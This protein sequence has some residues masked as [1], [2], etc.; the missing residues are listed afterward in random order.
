MLTFLNYSE[1]ADIII[2]AVNAS[3]DG[4]NA[5]LMQ[6]SRNLKWL[7]HIIRFKSNVWNPQKQVYDVEKRKC[8]SILLTLKKLQYWLYEMHF[9]LK[10]NANTLIV[11]LNQVTINLPGVLMI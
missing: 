7:K 10:I 6:V 8:W 5:V 2:L 3:S 4:W 1:E 11:Q 9:I